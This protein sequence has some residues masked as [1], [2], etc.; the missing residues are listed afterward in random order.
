VFG[1]V[2]DGTAV[3]DQIEKV[4]TGK[5]GFH[6]DVPVEDVVLTRAVVVE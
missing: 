2:V 5:R 1:R 6:D 3:V 4:R